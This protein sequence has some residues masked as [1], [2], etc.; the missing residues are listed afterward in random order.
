MTDLLAATP[1]NRLSYVDQ[2]MF[3]WLR[4][5]GEAPV[6]QIVWLYE[7]P[8]NF[9]EVRGCFRTVN[10][11]ALGRLRIE[12]SP[13]PFGRHRWVLIEPQAPED[14]FASSP[15]PR[16]EFTDWADEC[17]GLPIDPEWGP[18]SV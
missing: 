5:S 7:R 18:G 11:G 4:A 15:R 3:L 10:E 13:L 17:A 6:V 9:E 2:A 12:R 1:D 8:V 14:E 16:A